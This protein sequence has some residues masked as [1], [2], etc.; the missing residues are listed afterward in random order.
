MTEFLRRLFGGRVSPEQR[1]GVLAFMAEEWKLQSLQDAEAAR[2][3]D[4]LTKY[5]GSAT[6]DSSALA[7]IIPSARRQSQV[8]AD[9]RQRHTKLG[10]VPDEAGACYF[11]WAST[12]LALEEWA[13]ATLAWFEGTE[14][15]ATP[16]TGRVEQ[17]LLA[18]QRAEREARREEAKLLKRLGTS[19]EDVRRLIQKSEAEAASESDRPAMDE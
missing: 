7:E 6:P 4:V 16:H 18:E 10:P 15:G 1:E 3:N 5:G 13:S 14:A 17:L 19:A 12:Y 8:Y 2:H 9:L 11:K